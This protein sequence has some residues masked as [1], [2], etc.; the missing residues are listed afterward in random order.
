MKNGICFTKSFKNCICFTKL[1]QAATAADL[2]SL[3]WLLGELGW[4]DTCE[5]CTICPNQSNSCANF[6]PSTRISLSRSLSRSRS[7]PLSLSF[8]C[9]CL[10]FSSSLVL[11]S[12]CP[13]IFVL[14]FF[15]VLCFLIIS[16]SHV[17][18]LCFSSRLLIRSIM[19]CYVLSYAVQ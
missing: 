7:L 12:S 4:L 9:L 8:L 15:Y 16:F 1:G 17:V 5:F 3:G 14:L 10:S 19:S 11:S 2:G 18:F 6:V 13:P